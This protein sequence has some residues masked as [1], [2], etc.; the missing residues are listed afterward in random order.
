MAEDFEY[1]ELTPKEA[2]HLASRRTAVNI[3]KDIYGRAGLS[4]MLEKIPDSTK[5]KI[6]TDWSEMIERGMP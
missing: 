5:K 4:D 3:W 6:L 1:E 2:K